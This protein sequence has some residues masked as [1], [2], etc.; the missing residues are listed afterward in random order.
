MNSHSMFLQQARQQYERHDL[1]AHRTPFNVLSVLC[2]ERD[3]ENLHS[4]LLA[5]LL[6]YRSSDTERINLRDFLERVIGL[7]EFGHGTASIIREHFKIDILV[8]SHD[9]KSAIV[10]ENKIDAGDMPKQL[11]RYYYTMRQ[12]GCQEVHLVYLTLDGH[13]PSP[14]AIGD[15]D[16][17]SI[18]YKDDI[19]PW[20]DRC[21]HYAKEDPSLRETLAQYMKVLRKLTGADTF[22]EIHE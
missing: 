11:Q 3:E 12:Q 18:S 10:I 22:G 5:A 2:N 9:G 14:D 8:I 21:K 6:D 20:L 16:C 17:K 4:R 7:H 1:A 13:E 19:L 15:L